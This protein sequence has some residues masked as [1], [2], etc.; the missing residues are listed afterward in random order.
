MKRFLA[1][2]VPIAALLA[3]LAAAPLLVERGF[4]IT[5]LYNLFIFTALAESWYI[6]GGL[7]GQVFLGMAAF[8]GFGAYVFTMLC[9]GGLPYPLCIPL[10]GIATMVLAAVLTPTFKLRGVYFVV[11]SIYLGEI[12]KVI[13]LMSPA[14]GGARGLYLPLFGERVLVTYYLSLSLMI[15]AIST[16]QIMYNSRV[17]VALRAIRGDLDAAEMFGINSTKLRLLALVFTALLSGMVGATHALYMILVEPHSFFSIM[18]SLIPCFTT[19]VGGTGSL[20]GPVIGTLIYILLREAFISVSGE[21]YL[22]MLGALLII[23]M[24]FAPRG[25]HPLIQRLATLK[26][27]ARS[28]KR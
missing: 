24:R 23:I 27:L 2:F 4:L 19:I 21:V 20:Y 25:I 11:G 18:W 1:R 5:L 16:A 28:S 14:M 8:F 17:G 10:A 12:M 3:L 15:I 13:V 6:I 9:L 22:T 26:L 7:G